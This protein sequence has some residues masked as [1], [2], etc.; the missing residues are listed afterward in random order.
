MLDAGC[1]AGGFAQIWRHFNATIEYTG[2]DVSAPLIR[3]AKKLQPDLEFLHGDVISKIRLP[4]RYANVVQ[5]LGWLHWEPDYD[6]ALREFWRLTGEFLFFDVRLAGEQ[7]DAVIARQKLA[8]SSEW[9]GVTTT[10]YVVVWWNDFAELLISLRPRRILGYGYWG[11]PAL[12]VD[13]VKGPIC[14]AAFVLEKDVA[15]SRERLEVCIDLPLAWPRQF[16]DVYLLPRSDLRRI[17]P[18]DES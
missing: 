11:E 12:T 15:N 16:D 1:G 17:V 3:V 4:G 18:T 13:G 9:D 8:L 5:A 7:T 2:I 10:P 6:Q 14:F